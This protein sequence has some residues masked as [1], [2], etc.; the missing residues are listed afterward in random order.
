MTS[1]IRLLLKRSYTMV[2]STINKKYN[3]KLSGV[4]GISL[5]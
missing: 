2:K 5:N 1:S 4:K 3:M